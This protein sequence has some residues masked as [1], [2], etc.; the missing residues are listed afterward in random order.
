[1]LTRSFAIILVG[2]LLI[3]RNVTAAL[4]TPAALQ[5]DKRLTRLR[6]EAMKFSGGVERVRVWTKGNTDFA[7]WINRVEQDSFGFTDEASLHDRSIDLRQVEKIA[8]AGKN[9]PLFRWTWDQLQ[10]TIGQSRVTVTTSDSV[11]LEGVVLEMTPAEIIL[12]VKKTSD[13]QLLPKGNTALARGMITSVRLQATHIKGRVV[14]AATGAGLGSL[15]AF[16]AMYAETSNGA[17]DGQA[18]A[19]FAGTAGVAYMI[20]W[21]SDRRSHRNERLILIK[22]D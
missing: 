15:F 7:G 8:E 13:K 19:I 18:A 5:E 20:G 21:L 2:I 22:P 3:P 10:K 6:T 4:A 1:M 16:S 17:T 14:G 12:D 9:Q 11:R